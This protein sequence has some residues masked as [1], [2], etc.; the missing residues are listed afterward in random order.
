MGVDQIGVGLSY[1]QTFSREVLNHRDCIDLIELV[2]DNVRESSEDQNIRALASQF[3][4][5]C[6][7]LGLSVGTDERIDLEYA[8]R[9]ARVVK[10]TGAHWL[11]DHLAMTRVGGIDL[12]HLVPISFSRQTVEIVARNVEQVRRVID[13]PFILEN[14]SYY[15]KVPG[16]DL[17]EWQ[18]LTE[19]CNA[20]PCGLLLD[21]NNLLVNA[22]NHAYDPYEFLHGIPLDRVIQIHLAGSRMVDGL[23][24]DT[25][26]DRVQAEVWGYLSWVLARCKPRGI[27]LE[28]DREFPPF[29]VIL[30]ELA[31][32]RTLMGIGNVKRAAT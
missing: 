17:T 28:W 8:E 15:V 26:A 2:A 1:R 22:T 32:A 18:F 21:L 19:V 10:L 9:I 20:A 24:V 29:E 6:H 31:Q 23:R 12:N 13:V 25:H 3:P 11:S 5:A 4:I 7:S 16:S 30:D 14:I 27:I